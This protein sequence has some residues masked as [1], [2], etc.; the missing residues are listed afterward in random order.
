MHK[1]SKNTQIFTSTK[2]GY[3]IHKEFG[4]KINK[5]FDRKYNELHA[6]KMLS[7]LSTLKQNSLT[8]EVYIYF[9][10]DFAYA[11]AQGS[12]GFANI[13]NMISYMN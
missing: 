5:L 9:G 4:F 10:D 13:D 6:K 12:S 7:Y 3:N 11:G 2:L 8:N 1:P